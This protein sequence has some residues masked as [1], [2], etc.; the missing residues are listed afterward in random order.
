MAAFDAIHASTRRT[1]EEAIHHCNGVVTTTLIV[2]IH[3]SDE[4]AW[5]LM[6]K[7]THTHKTEEEEKVKDDAC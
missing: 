6:S 2:C 1:R 5:M 3:Y 4:S 7:K